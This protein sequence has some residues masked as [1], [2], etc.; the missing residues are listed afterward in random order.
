MLLVKLLLVTKI[1]NSFHAFTLLFLVKFK[2][3]Y[4][5]NNRKKNG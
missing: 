5:K 3:V 1:K 2:I 4:L